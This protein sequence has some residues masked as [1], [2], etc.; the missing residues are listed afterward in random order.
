MLAYIPLLGVQRELYRLPRSRE[1]FEASLAA[2]IDREANDIRLPLASMNPMA[3]DH[4]PPLLDQLIA[5]GAVDVG[6]RVTEK[7]ATSA[8]FA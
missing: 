1:R 8:T 6:R 5:A 2:T 7:S 4:A 3:K